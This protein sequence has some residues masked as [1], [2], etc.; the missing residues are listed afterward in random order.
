[1]FGAEMLLVRQW[2]LHDP[3]S[4]P[5]AYQQHPDNQSCNFY[6]GRGTDIVGTA[7]HGM[8]QREE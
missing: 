7:I 6:H 3:Q 5:L 1:M 8:A 4:N 2:L